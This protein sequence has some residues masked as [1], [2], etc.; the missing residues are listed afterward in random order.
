MER[1]ILDTILISVERARHDLGDA[2]GDD[3]DAAIAAIAAITVAELLVGLE[4]ATAR[5]RSHREALVRDLLAGLTVED[6]TAETA[7]AHATLLVA[8]RRQGR[9]QGGHDLIIAATALATGRAVVTTNARGFADL[10]GVEVR[11]VT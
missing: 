4:L 9:P 5:R 6:Y 1:L 8:T 2:V 3:D 7:R 11:S 10:P